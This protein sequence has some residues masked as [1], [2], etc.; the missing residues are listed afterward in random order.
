[1]SERVGNVAAD[2]KLTLLVRT[3]CHLCD[4]MHDALR[5][6]AAATGLAVVVIDVDDVPGLAAA[7]GDRVPVLFAGEPDE[8]AE[9]CR[10]RFDRAAVER[11]LARWL[12]AGA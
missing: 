6:L 2:A 3:D 10:F 5:P 12:P 1:V 4:E 11:A 9:L 7:Y 8:G